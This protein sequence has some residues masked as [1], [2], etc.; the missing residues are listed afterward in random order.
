MLKTILR[1]TSWVRIWNSGPSEMH[2]V[3]H[4]T[5]HA[6]ACMEQGVCVSLEVGV[7]WLAEL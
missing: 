5:L 3:I 2:L 4:K 6:L 1:F 7:C